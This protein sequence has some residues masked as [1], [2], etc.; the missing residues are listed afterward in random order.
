MTIK[1]F[2]EQYNVDLGRTEIDYEDGRRAYAP[3][4]CNSYADLVNYYAD[5]ELKD[6]Y[7]DEYDNTILVIERK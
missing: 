7:I 4:W 6:H 1:Q 2:V 5:T 3:G